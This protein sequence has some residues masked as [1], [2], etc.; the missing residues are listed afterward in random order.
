MLW[1]YLFV[2]RSPL[3]RAPFQ[4][5]PS[6]RLRIDKKDLCSCGLQKEKKSELCRD[7]R[8]NIAFLN[9]PYCERCGNRCNRN[10]RC[11]S[12]ACAAKLI[13][14]RTRDARRKTCPQCGK[15]FFGPVE[16]KFC[17]RNCMDKSKRFTQKCKLCGRVRFR[18]LNKL[19]TKYCGT[20]CRNKARAKN[21]PVFVCAGCGADILAKNTTRKRKYCSVE[22]F[23]KYNRGSANGLYRGNRRHDRGTDW[24]ENRDLVRE[25]DKV[26][27]SCG[28]IAR[29]SQKLSV[30]HIVPFRLCNE[31]YVAMPIGPTPNHQDN[32]VALCRPCHSVKTHTETRLLKGDL[33][34][35]VSETK[36]IIPIDRIKKALALW[37]L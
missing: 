18:P 29:R 32:L 11:C 13:W 26:C 31:Y 10:R 15:C 2:K 9:R 1:Q 3:K 25:R 8:Q 36:K 35:F 30:D 33:I 19:G 17:S 20:T 24:L 6:Q 12:H 37:G 14:D 22:C 5:H 28:E 16:A 23:K 4:R 34:G 7:C 27:V 21:K